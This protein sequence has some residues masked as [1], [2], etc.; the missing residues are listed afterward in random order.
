MIN[1]A[2]H[3]FLCLLAICRSPL[4]KCLFRSSVHFI[5]ELLVFLMLSCVYK[6]IF[7]FLSPQSDALGAYF[8]SLLNDVGHSA[9]EYTD[10]NEYHGNNRKRK[11]NDKRIGDV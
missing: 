10:D 7:H 1:I 11:T 8:D 9:V 6:Y 2:E 3:L 4:E 5:I